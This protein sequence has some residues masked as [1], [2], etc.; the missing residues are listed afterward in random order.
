MWTLLRIALRN[1]ARNRRRTLITLSALLVG[2]GAAIVTRAMMNGLQRTLVTNITASATGALQV[3]KTGYIKNVLATPLTMDFVADEALLAKVRSVPG[4]K[5]VAPRIQFAGSF[6]ANDET[7]FIAATA[8]DPEAEA[9]V[10]PSRASTFEPGSRFGDAD[11]VLLSDSVSKTLGTKVGAEAVFL[12]PDRDGALNGELVHMTG[13]TRSVMP[14]EPKTAVVP[15]ALAQRLLRMEGRATELGVAVERLEEVHAVAARIREVLGPDYEVH[16]W[17]ELLPQ[18][19]D[20]QAR[21]NAVLGAIAAVFLILMLLGVANT[22]LM[23]ALERTREIGTM[24]AVGLKRAKVMALFVM[25]ATVLGAV[26]ST[27]G[28]LVGVGLTLWLNQRGL[29]FTAPTL[30]VPFDLRPFIGV[31]YVVRIVLLSTA[32]AALFALYP[33]RRASRLRPV[34]AL[35]GR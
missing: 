7:L 27:L 2:V 31:D 23:S 10:T 29:V 3:H 33:A 22:I 1:V 5:A 14:G 30:S 11:G 20:G 19:R 32:G 28:V 25:E 21:Q 15:L 6:N 16:T 12:A 34:Q 9:A 4:V 26:G 13:A 8:L 24:M 17:D 35:A 18:I